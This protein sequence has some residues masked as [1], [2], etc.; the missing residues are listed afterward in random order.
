MTLYWA[1]H[2]ASI[3]VLAA[4]KNQALSDLVGVAGSEIEV[5]ASI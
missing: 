4:N 3:I 2:F 5:A 1:Q